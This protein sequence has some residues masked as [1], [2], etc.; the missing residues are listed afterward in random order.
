M[1][2]LIKLIKLIT[3]Y[4][5]CQQYPSMS[6][7]AE[8]FWND[9]LDSIDLEKCKKYLQNNHLKLN[10][11]YWTLNNFPNDLKPF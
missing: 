9:T 6:L 7:S 8:I 1:D 10:F 3:F 5:E 11:D 4:K 2:E